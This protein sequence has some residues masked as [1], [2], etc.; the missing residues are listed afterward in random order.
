MT[1]AIA[2]AEF[3]DGSYIEIWPQ[4]E[5]I[6]VEESNDA[7]VPLAGTQPALTPGV[8]YLDHRAKLTGRDTYDAA[9]E[10]LGIVM[11]D[12]AKGTASVLYRN[13]KDGTHH[14]VALEKF[15]EPVEALFADGWRT[16]TRFVRISGDVE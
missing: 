6:E 9:V 12:D 2:T 13:L 5:P 11:N 3:E 14:V 4:P 7:A 10:V 16:V 15:F 8:L 1:A